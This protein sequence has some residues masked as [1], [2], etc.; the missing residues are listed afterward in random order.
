V[1]DRGARRALDRRIFALAVPALGAIAAEPLY[2]LADTAVVGHLGRP[3]LDALAVAATLL[4]VLGWVT[5]FLTTVTTS[6]VAHGAGAGRPDRVGRA[7]GAALVVALPLGILSGG[8]IAVFAPELARLLGGT[9]SVGAA[10][11]YLRLSAPGLPFLLLSY[12]GAG[13]LTGLAKARTVLWIAVGAN[14][15]N[16]AL[17]VLLVFGAGLGL[18]GSALGT[19][20]AQVLAAAAYLLVGR[21]QGAEGPQ[22]P[23]LEEVRRLLHDGSKLAVRTIALDL[24][25]LGMT[26]VAARLGPVP[27]AGNQIAVRVW[28]LLALLLDGL[29]VPAQVFVS[30]ALGSD[31]GAGAVEVGRRTMELGVFA[32]AA[33]GVLTVGAAFALPPLLSPDAAVQAAARLALFVA[34]AGQPLASAAFVLDGLVLGLGDFAAL[35]RAMLLALV[36]FAPLA[37]IGASVPG[38]GLVYLWVAYCTWLA[39]RTV[40]LGWRWRRF[41]VSVA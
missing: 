2:G 7:A 19:V 26:A 11:T 37:V 13:H 34:A 17:E 23:R 21:R 40:L 4:S 30:G 25:P 8:L 15:A 3:Q 9:R 32:G 18:R 10:T 41:T 31:D 6:A 29:A 36:E 16:L 20:A 22:W 39:A 12:A 38:L 14:A 24:V 35:R 5:N 28:L 33:V 27:L 1:R